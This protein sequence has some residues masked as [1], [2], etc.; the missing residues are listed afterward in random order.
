MCVVL[1]AAAFSFSAGSLHAQASAPAHVS[2]KHQSYNP[3]SAITPQEQAGIDKDISRHF[4]SAPTNPGPRAKL[5]GSLNPSDVRAAMSKVANW[6]L[7]V[8]QPYFGRIWTWG[9]L[10]SGFMA[11]S[12]ALHD[13]RYR[14]AME[15]MAEK[16]DWKLDSPHPDANGQSLAQTYLEL[17]LEKPAPQKIA[18]TQAALNSVIK[19]YGPPIP[20]N[21]AQ[22][23]WWWCDALFMGP[24]AWTRMYAATHEKKY[25]NYLDKN[26]WETSDLLY[27]KHWHLY[28][29]D[30][31]YIHKTDKRGKPIFWSR[32]E[33][34]VMAGIART[35]EYLPKSDPDYGRYEKQLRQMAAAVAK[36]QDPKDGMWHADMLDPQ[37]FPQPE[38]SGSSLITFALAWGVNNGVLNRA[39][40]MPVIAKA[41]RGL[42]GQIYASGRL[43]NIQQTGAQP[44]HYLPSSSYTYGVGGFLMAGAQVVDLSAHAPMHGHHGK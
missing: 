16:F 9:V 29:R 28:H 41:W 17:Y 13:P 24:P 14:D 21:Q 4:G 39:K 15:K 38:T 27:D 42:V 1:L 32:G 25:L 44:A 11:A 33:G 6:Q 8:A 30:I 34:W 37:D 23:P 3:A 40:Y 35:L 22:I 18:P 5:S 43:G 10:Y 7:K 20:P 2:A 26:F 31:T 19:G 36:I 12:P